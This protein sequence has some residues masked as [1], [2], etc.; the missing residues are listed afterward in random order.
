[1]KNK[2]L[3]IASL[4]VLFLS[5]RKRKMSKYPLIWQTILK[6]ESKTFNDYN[7]YIQDAS[8]KTLLRGRLNPKDSLPFSQKLLTQCTL[9]EVMQFQSQ[10]R[11]KGQLWATGRFQI[12]PTTLKTMVTR[13]KIP[14]TALYSESIQYK[15]ADGLID[16]RRNLTN[17]LNGKVADTELNLTLA[18]L[19]VAKEWSSV[20]VPYA[21]KGH[22]KNVQKDESYYSGGLDKASVSSA[23]VMDVLKRQ[24]KAL[25]H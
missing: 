22:R 2:Y 21:M 16:G 24:R 3:Y 23:S 1:M 20:G 10:S 11:S 5:L 8:G 7:F 19:D 15:L 13:L 17:Y 12:I 18:V 14:V 25:G 4:G 6:G 9:S